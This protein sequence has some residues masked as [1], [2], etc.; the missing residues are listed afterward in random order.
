[1][2][3]FWLASE[4]HDFPEVSHAYS[5]DASH[6]PVRLE[7]ERSGDAAGRP[8][9]VGALPIENPPWKNFAGPSRVSRMA[10]KIAAMVEAAYRNRSA[11]DDDARFPRAARRMLPELDLLTLDPLDPRSAPSAPFR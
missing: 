1:M 4:D 11:L 5:F 10:P 9:P 3:I 6:Q 2:P 8:S 7:I